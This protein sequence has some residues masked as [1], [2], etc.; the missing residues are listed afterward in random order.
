MAFFSR[1]LPIV[2][3]GVFGVACGP[4][5]TTLVARGDINAAVCAAE[6]HS[7]DERIAGIAFVKAHALRFHV[8][9]VTA[10]ELGLDG[11]ARAQKFFEKYMILTLDTRF[12]DA[13]NGKLDASLDNATSIG[14]VDDFVR[15]TN[16]K[17]PPSHTEQQT[18]LTNDAASIWGLALITAGVS[19]L[20]DDRKTFHTE[21]V[22]VPPSGEEIGKAAPNA[23]VIWNA[24][25]RTYPKLSPAPY[26]L[27]RAPQASV[28]IH[29]SIATPEGCS[30]S[31]GYPE[32]RVEL[33]TEG[34]GS[35]HMLSEQ[36][37]R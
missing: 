32:W 14:A 24:L 5:V 23:T 36:S 18:T 25:H 22:D 21:K 27:E 1:A 7:P 8:H 37:P 11:D 6:R 3:F 12:D 9:E 15:Y 2:A 31:L 19:L 20:F 28:S 10:K 35:W 4:S 13:E 17:L 33:P 30:A 16:E 29:V 34:D 26:L